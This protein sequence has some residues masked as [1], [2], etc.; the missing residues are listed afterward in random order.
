MCNS[1]YDVNDTKHTEGG[2]HGNISVTRGST[3]VGKKKDGTTTNYSCIFY[4]FGCGYVGD[5]NGDGVG[6]YIWHGG[7]VEVSQTTEV[8]RTREKT[9]CLP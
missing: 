3:V 8:E 7:L 4:Y 1:H 5:N 9:S 6:G 2:E